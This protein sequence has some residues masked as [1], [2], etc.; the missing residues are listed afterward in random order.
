MVGLALSA[1]SLL[2]ALRPARSA[3]A[4]RVRPRA[5]TVSAAHP[6]LSPNGDGVS[7][8]ARISVRV[9]IPATLSVSIVDRAR[10]AVSR[11]ASSVPVRPGKFDFLWNGRVKG[12]GR[13]ARD[14]AYAALAHAEDATG[15]TLE[16]ERVIVVDTRP[17]RVSWHGSPQR[18]S[19]GFLPLSLRVAD[20]SSRV[21]LRVSLFDQAGTRLTHLSP[22]PRSPGVVKLGWRPRPFGRALAPGAYRVEVAAG[23]D[24]GNERTSSRRAILVD[25]P[26]PSRA[27]DRFSGAG[28]RVA[29][30][31]DDCSWGSAWGSILRTL[32]AHA[33]KGTFFCPGRQVLANPPLARRTVWDGHSIGSHGW[34]HANF[35][36]LPYGSALARLISDREVWWRLA[37]ASPTPFFR[38]PYGAF[39]R[40]VV[41]AAGRAGYAT[42]VLWDVDPFD[43]RRPGVGVITSRVLRGARS[44]SVILL[45]AAPQT[46]AALP[47]IIRGL[48]S[49]GLHPVTLAELARHGTPV[50]GRPRSS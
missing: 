17:P 32:R 27:V 22:S 4:G 50:P 9:E 44:G 45:H 2:V 5:L 38:P 6:V 16:A 48:R 23:D 29:L 8:T 36:R 10:R 19:S 46:A 1:V 7:E 37:R 26:T 24:V 21:R 11:L 12:G 18:L 40:S 33:T 13:P 43:W 39:N 30:T 25:R 41:A 47:A 42:I 35:A 3:E 14:G 28:R 31:F 49:R 20:R 15:R 34:D